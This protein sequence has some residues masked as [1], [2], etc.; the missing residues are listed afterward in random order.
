MRRILFFAISVFYSHQSSA[1][2]QKS[3]SITIDDVPNTTQYLEGGA[4]STL[5]HKL[6]TMD[7]P[8]TIFINEDKISK[9]G[10]IAK[11]KDL[12]E[13]WVEHR[14]SQIGNHSYS[15]L[16]YSDVGYTKFVEDIVK[17][18]TLTKVYA[19]AHNKSLKYF[20]FPFNDLGKDSLQ[21]MQIINY[22]NGRGYRVAPFTVESSDWMYDAVYTHYRDKGDADS[23][24]KIGSLYVNRTIELV[25]FFEAMAMSIYMRPV[26]QIYLCHDNAINADYLPD[27]INLL[28]KNG[29]E[30]IGFDSSLSDPVYSQSDHYYKK[31]G[32]SWMYRWMENQ[33][34]RIKWMKQE[35]D[36]SAIQELYNQITTK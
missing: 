32:V 19:K 36:M 3:I 23:A 9:A 4:K 18:E 14:N 15:H 31:W 10:D 12:L 26:K 11:N 13:R 22:L 1:Q 20:R 7:V 29:Y 27:I 35:P 30:I 21:H 34:E 2:Q 8:F 28:K 24:K 17:G 16:R 6:D 5:L 33:E 25:D